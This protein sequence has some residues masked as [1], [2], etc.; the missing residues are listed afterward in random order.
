VFTA[1][2]R[3]Q[4]KAIG[5]PDTNSIPGRDGRIEIGDPLPINR[6]E[7]SLLGKV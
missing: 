4:Q 2:H 7:I 1:F 5:L 6:Y 3:L